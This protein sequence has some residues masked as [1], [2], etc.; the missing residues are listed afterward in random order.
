M[1]GVKP[2]TYADSVLD[3]EFFEELGRFVANCGHLEKVLWILFAR[4]A[5]LDVQNDV[6]AVR[7][8]R[9]SRKPF[10]VLISELQREA[11]Q[12][13]KIPEEIRKRMDSLLDRISENL[14]YRNLAVHGAWSSERDHYRVSFFDKIDGAANDDINSYRAYAAPVSL[15]EIRQSSETT[16]KF[17]HEAAELM[18]VIKK[19]HEEQSL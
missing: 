4:V 8:L 19:W 16:T 14:V 10:G 3:R 18:V 17:L 11:A 9:I 13:Q 12:S 1:A 15:A 2:V 7:A 5:Q 6:D